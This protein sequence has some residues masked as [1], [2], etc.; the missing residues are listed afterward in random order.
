MIWVMKPSSFQPQIKMI[1]PN[2]LDH[3]Y[4]DKERY[5]PHQFHLLEL[6]VY[7]MKR[8]QNFGIKLI[9]IPA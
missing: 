7:L 4:S 2:G 9:Q 5:F 8:I 3:G 1:C 6:L